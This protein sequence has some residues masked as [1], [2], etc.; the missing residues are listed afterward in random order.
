[1]PN[2][3]N[4]PAL[5][6]GR[7]FEEGQQQSCHP[8]RLTHARRRIKHCMSGCKVR[9]R[10]RRLKKVRSKRGKGVYYYAW[11][12]GPRIATDAAPGT[13]EFMQA[14]NE[15]IAEAKPPDTGKFSDLITL[16]KKS[17]EFTTRSAKTQKDYFRYIKLIE[18]KFGTVPVS[19]LG[20]RAVRGVFKE[21]QDE[22]ATNG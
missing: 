17:T 2:P 20:A 14:Y 18:A 5:W 11:V 9:I 1:M 3:H 13:P 22:L 8:A 7:G 16:Y 10:L 6:V 15:A 12:G 4:L 21:W 19:A